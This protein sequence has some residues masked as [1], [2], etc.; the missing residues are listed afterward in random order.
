MNIRP[1]KISDT[2]LYHQEVFK[3]LTE[4]E[5]ARAQRYPSPVTLLHISLNLKE[6]DPAI[7]E[8][9]KQIFAGIL[10][11]CL[12]VSDIPAHYGDDFVV[13]L[14]VTDDVGGQAVAQRLI[15]RLQGTRNFADGNMFKFS[16]H[17]GISTH[18][19]GRNISADNLLQQAQAALE[20]ARQS[21]PQS[22]FL[23]PG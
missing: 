3:I 1:Y 10:N 8:S 23:F 6:A 12:R 7:S 2:G 16:I 9:V 21:G 19:G 17:I 15:S 20:L 14:P 18:P 13:L 11:T 22:Y 5:L 4:Y